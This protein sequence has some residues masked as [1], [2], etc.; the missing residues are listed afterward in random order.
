MFPTREIMK[1]N[2]NLKFIVCQ[3][4]FVNPVCHLAYVWMLLISHMVSLT[5]GNRVL[6]RESDGDLE[7][8][9]EDHGQPSAHRFFDE[10]E[11]RAAGAEVA[12][13][14]GRNSVVRADS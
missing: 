1:E 14:L 8:G 5:P 4:E 13:A 11:P 9:F 3:W 7:S 2:L 10:G 6:W 12:R